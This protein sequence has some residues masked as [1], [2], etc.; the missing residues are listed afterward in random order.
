[1]PPLFTA[2]LAAQLTRSTGIQVKE[3]ADGDALT[4]GGALLAPGGY[5]MVFQSKGGRGSVSLNEEDK[6]NGCRP[7]VDVLFGSVADKFSGRTLAVVLTGMGQD[8]ADGV[9]AL[10]QKG[11]TFC[12]S[13]DESSCVVY[14]MPRAVNERGL[15]DEVTPVSAIG[16]RIRELC[17]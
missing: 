6:V 5:H 12:I 16:A 7:A 1:M 13:Q 2:S 4:A 8:G 17:R 10:K 3:A 11:H 15:V 14:G 9:A